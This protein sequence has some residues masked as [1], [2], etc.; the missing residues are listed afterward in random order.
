MKYLVLKTESFYSKTALAS[1]I[2]LYFLPVVTPCRNMVRV[3]T[4]ITMTV[5]V[6]LPDSLK[7]IRI[8]AVLKMTMRFT[9]TRPI[10]VG[11]ERY[12]CFV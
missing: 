8:F 10:S 5:I 2:S 6:H 4:P 3:F 1:N 9:L 12:L 7:V 11:Q